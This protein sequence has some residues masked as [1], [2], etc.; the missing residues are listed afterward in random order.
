MRLVEEYDNGKRLYLCETRMD[1]L[2][3]KFGFWWQN[4][5]PDEKVLLW[6]ALEVLTLLSGVALY[7]WMTM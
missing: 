1:M 7:A 5:N 3:W 6:F 4:V 2:Q